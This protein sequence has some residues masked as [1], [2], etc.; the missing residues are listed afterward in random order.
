MP[1]GRRKVDPAA[2]IEVTHAGV[3][4][5]T[6]TLGAILRAR[7]EREAVE[8][9]LLRDGV[10]AIGP[11]PQLIGRRVAAVPRRVASGPRATVDAPHELRT[12]DHESAVLPAYVSGAV[13]GLP[14]DAML[15][16]AVN[17]RVEATTRVLR[18]DA[19]LVY[20]ALVPPA[21]LKDG[22]NTA[23]V[24]QVLPGDRLRPIGAAP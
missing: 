21:S 3:P 4:A 24:L 9:A 2:R 14:A 17:G 20:A 18:S 12:I 8:A 15:A 13:D 7:R 16:V 22:A 23:M 1:A 5:L 6:T 10:Y 11:A 19:G